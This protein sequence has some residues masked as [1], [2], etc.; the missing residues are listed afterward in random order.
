MVFLF[1]FRGDGIGPPKRLAFLFRV[2]HPQGGELAGSKFLDPVLRAEMKDCQR[3]GQVLA[4][5]DFGGGDAA[6][7]FG[8]FR[9]AG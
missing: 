4:M 9:L 5:D 1:G 3:G 2:G 8:K 7:H 6:S